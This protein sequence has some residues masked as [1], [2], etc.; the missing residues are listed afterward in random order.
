MTRMPTM[1]SPVSAEPEGADGGATGEVSGGGTGAAGADG[2]GV[3][4]GGGSWETPVWAAAISPRTPAKIAANPRRRRRLGLMALRDGFALAR[5]DTQPLG[6]D[7]HLDPFRP[8]F[9]SRDQQLRDGIL[10]V[11][12][13]CAPEGASPHVGVLA[14][15]LEQPLH[16][17]VVH[18]DPRALRRDGRVHVVDQE[19]ADL[20][21]IRPRQGME[22]DDVVDPVD[23]LW[24]EVAAELLQNELFDLLVA[25]DFA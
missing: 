1:R 2:G 22:D 25:L 14:A 19:A 13:D 18:V 7:A 10:D 11:L 8:L 24:R 3:G 17:G 20:G 16:G 9:A 12:L 5:R 6:A 4:S 21:Q 15:L 23:E